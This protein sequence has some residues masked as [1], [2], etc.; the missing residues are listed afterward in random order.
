M[1]AKLLTTKVV[2]S[3][4]H[5][6]RQLLFLNL[7]TTNHVVSSFEPAGAFVTVAGTVDQLRLLVVFLDDGHGVGQQSLG[8]SL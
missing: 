6:K 5:L 8:Q 3:S 7:L 1:R 2:V 4:F